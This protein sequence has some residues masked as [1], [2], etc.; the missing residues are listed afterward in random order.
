VPQR[1]GWVPFRARLLAGLG[2]HLGLGRIGTPSLFFISYS[3][4][5]SFSIFLICF[6]SFAYL[7]QFDPNKFLKSSN[8]QSNVVNQ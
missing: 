4:S 5:I 6:I 7:L 1:V 2:R 8:H 3:F